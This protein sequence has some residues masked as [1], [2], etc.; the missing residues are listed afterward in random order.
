MSPDVEENNVLSPDVE[1]NNVLSTDVE[2]ERGLVD[3]MLPDVEE[4]E[5][6]NRHEVCQEHIDNNI[7][8][9]YLQTINADFNA[10]YKNED[11]SNDKPDEYEVIKSDTEENIGELP[12][13]LEDIEDYNLQE[14]RQN[15]E[16]EAT[17]E[18]ATT[19]NED[20]TIDTIANNN[21][22]TVAVVNN[23]EEVADGDV[24]PENPSEDDSYD[25]VTE[26]TDSDESD[27]KS[28]N[29][30]DDKS[31]V[32]LAAPQ[33]PDDD[34]LERVSVFVNIILYFP[35]RNRY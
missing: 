28:D 29:K 33:K 8:S 27:D 13:T 12:H 3:V 17:S 7:S 32:E 16:E 11:D 22:E 21:E 2:M 30:S 15:V 24:L 23:N 4:G 26:D 5:G 19:N 18:G 34:D 31:E 20:V 14:T 1:E 10:D 25:K 35:T 6:G 9:E